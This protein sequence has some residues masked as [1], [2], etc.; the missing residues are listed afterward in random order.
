MLDHLGEFEA[1]KRL[2]RAIET[3]TAKGEIL[4]HDLGGG[5]SNAEVTQ[6]IIAEIRSASA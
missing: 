2:M 6:A 5:A 4:P 3:V 1:S